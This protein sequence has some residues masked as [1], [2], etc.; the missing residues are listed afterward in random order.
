MYFLWLALVV[1]LWSGIDY[2]VKVF[3]G[4]KAAAAK[5]G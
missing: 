2:H 5:A 1:G 4:Y 3:R